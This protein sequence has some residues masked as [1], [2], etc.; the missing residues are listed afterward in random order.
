MLTEEL[1]K[2]LH[3]LAGFPS[4]AAVSET[5]AEPI[6]GDTS[7]DSL[8]GFFQAFRPDGSGLEGAFEQIAVGEQLRERL[9]LLFQ[10][11]GEDRRPQGGRDAYFVVRNPSPI[12][13]SESEQLAVDWL[14]RM[15]D[16]ALMLGDVETVSVLQP[17]P[18]IRVLEGIPPKH[19]KR[20][21]EKSELLKTFQYDIAMLTARIDAADPHAPVLRQAYYFIACDPM[22]RDYLMW[23]LYAGAAAVNDPFEPY[24][25]L[26]SHG[27]KYRIFG[28]NQIDL[29]LPRTFEND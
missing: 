28:E 17:T 27:V 14:E 10:V 4:A 2:K 5:T 22:L 24:F 18:A 3:L 6:D 19:P 12:D 20:D 8:I 29:Y 16:L 9:G 11:A 1:V 7:A 15:R 23:P 25:R 21:E 13:P 26:W